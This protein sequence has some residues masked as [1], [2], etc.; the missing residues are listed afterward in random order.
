MLISN[1]KMKARYGNP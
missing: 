1:E